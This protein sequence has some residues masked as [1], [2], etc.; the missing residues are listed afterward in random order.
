MHDTL[1]IDP[2]LIDI[3][4]A[5]GYMCTADVVTEYPFTPQ[6]VP[7]E[8]VFAGATATMNE[9]LG[10]PITSAFGTPPPTRTSL[11]VDSVRSGTGGLLADAITRCRRACW[12][13][14]HAVYGKRIGGELIGRRSEIGRVPD[15]DAVDRVRFLKE[16][17]GLM[18]EARR[19]SGGH[20]P[21]GSD[22]WAD[23]WE[24]HGWNASDVFEVGNTPWDNFA[25]ATGSPTARDAADGA[26]R[27]G[28][29]RIGGVL[30]QSAPA[31]LHERGRAR[32]VRRFRRRHRSSRRVPLR[33]PARRR[34]Q[35]KRLATNES[36]RA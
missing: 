11:F 5:Y 12:E 13:E 35:L 2:G 21:P 25:S 9:S 10:S 15:P 29:R 31:P 14:E 34:H 18:V 17:L 28:T 19:S 23:M 16:L 7:E 22:G 3:N 4:I 20:L 8:L 33:H 36:G 32:S 24:R 27:P 30:P 1:T 26:R 6:L